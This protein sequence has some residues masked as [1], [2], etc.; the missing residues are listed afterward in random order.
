MQLRT[1]F[2]LCRVYVT[3][4][5]LRAFDRRPMR[6]AVG[7]CSVKLLE[8]SESSGWETTTDP[9]QPAKSASREATWEDQGLV[10]PTKA[11]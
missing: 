8:S 10:S 7:G 3:S 9:Q 6:P 1:E 2:T 5:N 4:G 11:K